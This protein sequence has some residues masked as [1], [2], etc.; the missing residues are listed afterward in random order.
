[1]GANE[2]DLIGSNCER[3]ESWNSLAE[4][5][6]HDSDSIKE[7]C[8]NFVPEASAMEAFSKYSPGEIIAAAKSGQFATLFP[9]LKDNLFLVTS[10]P[11]FGECL[12]TATTGE[13]G[14]AICTC[15]TEE[16]NNQASLSFIVDPE[17]GPMRLLQFLDGSLANIKDEVNAV[18][19]G[20]LQSD[21][22]IDAAN[23]DGVTEADIDAIM[24]L[25]GMAKRTN[26]AELWGIVQ[27]FQKLAGFIAA[28]GDP[29]EDSGSGADD[30]NKKLNDLL[31]DAIDDS[32]ATSLAV[33][34][35]TI[36]AF[37]VATVV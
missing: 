20:L 27:D 37:I 8:D 3:T 29:D 21:G 9:G 26:K 2:A 35:A 32:S 16:C 11:E 18:V 4:H 13:F 7:Y 5:I 12:F 23:V 1:L 31:N 25:A 30:L 19:P 17:V 15:D 33:G 10:K 24:K 34:I 28:G 36:V 6:G 22:K 14:A